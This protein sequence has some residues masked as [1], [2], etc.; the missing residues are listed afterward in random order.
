MRRQRATSVARHAL[1]AAWL[2]AAAGP[3]GALVADSP[4]RSGSASG[5]SSRSGGSPS[6][7]AAVE[8][9]LRRLTQDLLDAVAPG[10]V[11]VWE[12]LL[13]ERM[14]H[15]D[16]NGVVRSKA[17]LLAELSPLPPGLVGR[18]DV[19]RFRVERHG[20]VAVAAVEVQEHLDYHGQVI[21][22]RFRMLD[23]WRRTADGWRLIA[24]HVAA[25]LKDPPAI[26]LT[27]EE[28]CAYEGTYELT[29][30]IRTTIRCTD[31]G[32]VSE[33][34][35]RPPVIYRPELR[36][37]FFAP[38]QP[39]SRRLFTRDTAGRVAAFLDRREGEDVRWRRVSAA[40]S[41]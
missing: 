41:D 39:R 2:L 14:V 22:S 26:V 3:A 19:D 33:R 15:L 29:A 20:E 8:T 18:I 23:T 30:E 5:E 28:L 32:L 36:D 40:P 37:L 31:D 27:R 12:R 1:A 35:T 13:D 16:E 21:R 10:R 17:E 25:V 9:E 4:E 34:T 38:G 24:Q 11:E 7:S 6:D